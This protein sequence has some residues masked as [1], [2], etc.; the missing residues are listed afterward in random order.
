M[1]S[2]SGMHAILFQRFEE[3]DSQFIRT[4]LVTLAPLPEPQVIEYQDEDFRQLQRISKWEAK[5]K[6]GMSI[7]DALRPEIQSDFDE[8]AHLKEEMAR[9]FI[10]KMQK[11]TVERNIRFKLN[12]EKR[13][14]A[15]EQEEKDKEKA[16]CK[17]MIDQVR[18]RQQETL[19]KLQA[20]FQNN[21]G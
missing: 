16:K 8:D 5:I 9:N 13:L 17:E 20:V 6:E 3:A 14:A 10:D 19:L 21:Q 12:A 1:N 2:K 7:N 11:E 18:K 4:M 15:L